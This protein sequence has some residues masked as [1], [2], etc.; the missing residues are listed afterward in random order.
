[1]RNK[2]KIKYLKILFLK[3]DLMVEN[4]RKSHLRSFLNKLNKT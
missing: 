1:M 4:K 3:L 2:V